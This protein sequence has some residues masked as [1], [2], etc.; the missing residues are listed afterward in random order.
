MCAYLLLSCST[1]HQAI[2]DITGIERV[3]IEQEK[4]TRPQLYVDNFKFSAKRAPASS[5]AIDVPELSNR[6]LYFLTFYKQYLMLGELIGKDSKVKA[7]PSFH[8]VLLDYNKDLDRKKVKLTSAIKLDYV[9]ENKKLLSKFPV[10]ALP[11]SSRSDLFSRLERNDWEDSQSELMQAL[12]HYHEIETKEIATLCDTG[13]SPS[14]YVYENLVSYF[15]ND[16][17]F[18]RTR[19]GLKALLKVPVIANMVILDNLKQANYPKI[20]GVNYFDNWLIERSNFA[21]F[22]EYRNEVNY[23]R[24]VYLSANY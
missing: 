12:K 6:Q 22:K 11:Y 4:Y 5:V 16:Q 20:S 21:W 7:C 24:K 3:E 8:N 1:V 10:L 2:D 19:S 23:G 13:V 9:K 15:K 17:S 14:Y 18:H